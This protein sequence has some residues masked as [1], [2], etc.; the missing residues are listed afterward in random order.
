MEELCVKPHYWFETEIDSR[1]YICKISRHGYSFGTIRIKERMG[2][3]KRK[4]YYFFGPM[5][6]VPVFETI[7]FSHRGD[8]LNPVID[9]R[10]Y[11]TATFIKKVIK[12]II[13]QKP[14]P[15]HSYKI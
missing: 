12:E 4:Q 8:D 14:N 11:Y 9:Y 10:T 3:K 5:I 7:T 15:S 13:E 6:D 1:L 2:I